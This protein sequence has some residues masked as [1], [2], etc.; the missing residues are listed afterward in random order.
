M[1]EMREHERFPF[2]MFRG[3]TMRDLR[4]EKLSGINPFIG[5]GYD[6]AL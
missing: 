6:G 4:L 2:T 5:I 1:P 3:G